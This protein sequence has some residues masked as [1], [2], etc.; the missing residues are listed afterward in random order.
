MLKINV[1]YFPTAFIS[2]IAAHQSLKTF[3]TMQNPLKHITL[4]AWECEQSDSRIIK[5]I[6]S[7]DL[8]IMG[9]HTLHI[10]IIVNLQ[11][12]AVLSP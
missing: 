1:A 9:I 5:R 6:F 12:F 4:S 3:P 8:Y 2:V 10:A 7:Q 11:Y